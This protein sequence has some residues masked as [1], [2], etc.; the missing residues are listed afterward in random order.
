MGKAGQ[1]IYLAWGSALLGWKRQVRLQTLGLGFSYSLRVSR[2]GKGWLAFMEQRGSPTANWSAKI[3][4]EYEAVIKQLSRELL[5]GWEWESCTQENA[6]ARVSADR[7]CLSL[8]LAGLR[9]KE[10]S[11]RGSIERGSC[12]FDKA[13]EGELLCL[14]WIEILSFLC[15]LGWEIE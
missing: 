13:R 11:E 5:V 9:S 6:F 15:V 3:R 4:R 2:L 12:W 14:G 10:S 8:F 1:I 7:I